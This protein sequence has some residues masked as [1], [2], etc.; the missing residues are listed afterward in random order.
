[1]QRDNPD[2]KVYVSFF[3]D[4]KANRCYPKDYTLSEL[5]QLVLD[6]T[7]PTKGELPWL[8]LAVF[9]NTLSKKGS[10]R[11]NANV[12]EITGIELDYDGEKIPFDVVL[13]ALQELRIRALFYTSP[14]HKADAPRWRVVCP[15]A[16]LLP[17]EVRAKLVA[18]LNG[19]LKDKLGITRHEKLA[20]DESF[21]LSQSFYYGKAAD[22]PNPDHR[23]EVIEGAFID[24]RDDLEIYEAVGAKSGDDEP[25]ADPDDGP[26]TNELPRSLASLLHIKDCG[27]YETRSELLFA[28]ITGALRAGIAKATIIEACLDAT[29]K[30]N[31]IFEH[32][33]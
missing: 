31:G 27:A 20:A 9:G 26:R 22:N 5:R 19:S 2:T 13:T 28:F 6:T 15:T 4:E 18:K 24:L 23:A 8:K 14:S 3:K 11:H 1:M 16:K 7:K 32:V 25:E 21:R 30:G 17:V 10:L 12:L 33:E 29:Y